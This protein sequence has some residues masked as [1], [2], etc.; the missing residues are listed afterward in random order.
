MCT[1]EDNLLHC[2]FNKVQ[3]SSVFKNTSSLENPT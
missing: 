2:N 1:R 3:E